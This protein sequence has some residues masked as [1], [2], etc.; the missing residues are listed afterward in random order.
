M[1]PL[2]RLDLPHGVQ[3][4]EFL[5]HKVAVVPLLKEEEVVVPLRL[6]EQAVAHGG[7]AAQLFVNLGQ[8]GAALGVRAGV[9]QVLVVV[10]HDDAHHQAGGVEILPEAVHLRGIHPVGGRH[11]ILLPAAA[12]GPDQ[13]AVDPETAVVHMDPLRAL[14]PPLQQPLDGELRGGIL[15]L[16]LKEVLP[17]PRQLEEVLVAPDDLP[18]VG[19]EDHDGQG[20]VDEGGFAGGVHVSRYVVDILQDALAA[21]F[22]AADKVGV[23]RHG[24]RALRQ[25]QGR[26][27][28]DGGQGKGQEA[29][30]VKL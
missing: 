25:G 3:D 4:G 1:A 13:A 22:A 17:D 6:D 21:L 5:L 30:E 9:H 28:G 15:H 12:L 10:H 2:S 27:D 19:A 26:A 14:L 8:D 18:G 24:R 29:E 11:Q 7:P 20:G 16:H 23:Q